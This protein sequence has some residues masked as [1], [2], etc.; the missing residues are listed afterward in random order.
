MKHGGGGG[1]SEK[2]EEQDEEKIGKWVYT[3]R[4]KSNT[5]GFT[6]K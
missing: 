6:V 5:R 4:G 1:G 3:V 2:E